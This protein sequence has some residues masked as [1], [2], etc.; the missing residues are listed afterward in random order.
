MA[1][2]LVQLGVAA[3]ALGDS[4]SALRCAEWLAIDHWRPSL[5]TTHDAGRI[6]N[7]DASGGLP[8]VVAAMLFSSTVDTLTVLPA[9]P[10]EWVEG[11]VTGLRARGGVVVDRLEWDAEGCAIELRRLPEAH[12]LNPEGRLELRA[13]R[14]FRIE[15]HGRHHV[16]LRA[17]ESI[18]LRLRWMQ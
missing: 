5:T 6:F 10:V 7:L 8:A 12:W 9:V 17:G 2:G 16:T 1:F 11:A 4:A 13:G 3:A 14:G 15:G 18:A